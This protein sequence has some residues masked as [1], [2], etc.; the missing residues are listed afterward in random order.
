MVSVMDPLT[1]L[2][3][4]RRDGQRQ[5]AIGRWRQS[6]P[7]RYWSARLSHLD[8]AIILPIERWVGEVMA[9]GPT[10]LVFAGAV[11]VGK[12]YA[13]VAATRPLMLQNRGVIFRPMADAL[14]RM[15]PGDD[16]SHHWELRTLSE[17]DI[18]VLDD[19]GV[20]NDTPWAAEKV[21][22]L[23]NARWLAGR[24]TVVTTDLSRDRLGT[25][26]GER[27]WSRIG[28]GAVVLRLTGG[29]RRG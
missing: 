15:R 11:G 4:L 27:V 9:G 20:Y 1:D 29:D 7:P 16:E 12:T 6:I 24:P 19:V 3:V 26:L 21:F 8:S 25:I 14:E 2:A 18:L 13:A 22:R 10:N 5:L 28:G 17:A 23:F